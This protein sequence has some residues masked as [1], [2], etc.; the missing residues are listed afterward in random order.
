MSILILLTSLC[1]EGTPVLGLDMARVWQREGVDFRV[2]TFQDTPSDMASE[3]ASAGIEVD[4]LAMSFSSYRK[5]PELVWRI[6]RYCRQHRI[7]SVL[8]FP[9][10]WHSYA[11]WGSALAGSRRVVAHAGN[12]PPVRRSGPLRKLRATIA[13]GEIWRPQIACCSNH[14]RSGLEHHL[15]VPP[16]RLHTVYN[17]V[18]LQRFHDRTRYKPLQDPIRIGMVARFEAHKDQST[19]LHAIATLRSRGIKV[20]IDLVGDG[21][22]RAECESLAKQLEICEQ[23]RFMGVRR[24]VPELLRNWDAFV[25]SVTP[26]E[27]LGV[28]LVEALAAGVPVIASDVGACREVLNCPT[29]GILGNLFPVGDAESL[30]DAILEYKANPGPWWD[31]AAIAR[32]SVES[33]F[34]IEAMADHYLKLLTAA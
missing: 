22:R 5:F 12:Y 3:Y 17:G 1:A 28:A 18:D 13:I 24:D 14:V 29:Y 2:C 30:A 26:D 11:A 16:S 23:V 8:S 4:S 25:F 27:G 34:S 21:T 10:G 6:Q 19:L 31:R 33:R 20:C 9:F 32:I 7:E 15:H